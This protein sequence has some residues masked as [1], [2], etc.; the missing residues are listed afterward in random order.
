MAAGIVKLC[1]L[2][3][4]ARILDVGCGCG[5]LARGL[6]AYL[7]SEGVA[8]GFDVAPVLIEWSKQQLEPL[9]P[10]LHFSLADLRTPDFNPAGII[11]S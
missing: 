5:R 1:G 9:L 4:N 7:H 2:P 10:N 6:A 8:M 11:P 3:P